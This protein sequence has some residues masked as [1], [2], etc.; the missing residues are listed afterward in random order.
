MSTEKKSPLYG[1]KVILGVTGGIAAYKAVEIASRMRKAGAEVHVIMTQAAQNFVTELTFREISGNPVNTSMWS[2]VTHWNV[3]HIALARLADVVL[4]APV[5]ANLLAKLSCG[6]ADDMLTTTILATKAPVFL[7]P[8]MNSNMYENPI[9]QENMERLKKLGMKVIPPSCGHLAC[10]E[11]GSGRLPEA[12]E[13][14]SVLERHFQS[15]RTLCGKKVLVTAG[16]TIA[17]IDPVRFIGNRSSGKMGYAVAEE[18]ARRGAEVVLVAGRTALPNPSG[19][20][21]VHTETTQEMLEAVMA[22]FPNTDAVIK[23]AAVADYRVKEVAEQKIKKSEGDWSIELARNPDILQE[24]GKIKKSNQ[25]LVGFAAETQNLME[26]AKLKLEKKN[27][28]F[29]VANNVTEKGAGF[30]GETNIACL[31]HRDGTVNKYPLMK[32]SDLAAVI[33][34]CVE[35]LFLGK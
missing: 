21:T 32:K 33:M 14:V 24:L 8:A 23:A 26:Y 16:G 34:D 11:N 22:E 25:I 15:S 5:T 3:E 7:V 27:L 19:V 1:K 20:R 29:I 18:A 12:A 9:T 17:P 28:D 10:G 6:M 35:E 31:L 4:V 30:Q 13:I 2:M